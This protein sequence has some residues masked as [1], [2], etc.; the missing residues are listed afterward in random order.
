MSCTSCGAGFHKEC[1]STPCCC[2]G[3]PPVANLLEEEDNEQILHRNISGRGRARDSNLKDQQS[4]GRK[5][6]ALD[7]PLSPERACEW[8]ALR[9]AGGGKHPI[10]GCHDGK[11]QAR[12]HGPDKNTLNNEIGNVHRI[13]ANCHNRWHTANDSEYT[14]GDYGKAHNPTIQATIDEI[15]KNE[16]YWI[17]NKPKKTKVD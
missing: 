17:R 15:A 2:E 12:H 7:Y 1:E 4:T 5:R 10:I 8:K 16:A 14:P 3:S 9:Y 6:A 11:Q 13:C